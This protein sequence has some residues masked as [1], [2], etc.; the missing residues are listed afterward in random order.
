MLVSKPG[1]GAPKA[2]NDLVDHQ[3]DIIFFAD[4][5][6]PWPVAF[7]G[8]NHAAACCDGLKDQ[9]ANGVGTFAQDDIFN[10]ICRALARSFRLG[11][12][13]LAPLRDI[14]GNEAQR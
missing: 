6:H 13:C 2:A 14:Q 7:G 10:R 1:A 3:Q 8:H 5:L 12:G 9:A 11:R 4:F